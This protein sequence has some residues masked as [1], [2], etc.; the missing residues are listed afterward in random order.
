[1]AGSGPA[2]ERGITFVQKPF[3][4]KVLAEA[5]RNCLDTTP[6]GMPVAPVI[7]HPMTNGLSAPRPLVANV[8]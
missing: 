4:G 1:L 3:L 8:L 5:V 7:T 6:P 2:K